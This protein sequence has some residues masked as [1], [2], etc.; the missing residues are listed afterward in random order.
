MVVSYLIIYYTFYPD[1]RPPPGFP[2]GLPPR[3]LPPPGFPHEMILPPDGM[4]PPFDMSK[5]IF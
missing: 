5:S 1:T 3:G 2:H 4:M